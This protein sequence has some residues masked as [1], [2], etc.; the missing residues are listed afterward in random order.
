MNLLFDDLCVLQE[1]AVCLD[2]PDCPV[3]DIVQDNR[4]TCIGIYG[5]NRDIG[6]EC[7]RSKQT[8]DYEVLGSSCMSHIVNP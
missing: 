1:S 7:L 2:V 6:V 4:H 5:L 8:H 3:L